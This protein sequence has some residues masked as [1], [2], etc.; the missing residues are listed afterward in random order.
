MVEM[1]HSDK[2]YGTK[3]LKTYGLTQTFT[4]WMLFPF[5]QWGTKKLSGK[6]KSHH[7]C[8]NLH[9]YSQKRH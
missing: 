2:P 5:L 6:L 7:W 1:F 8:P 3:P 9:K 4:I